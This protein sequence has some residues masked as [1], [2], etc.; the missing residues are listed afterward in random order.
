MPALLQ[1][2]VRRFRVQLVR[3]SHARTR[4]VL[5]AHQALLAGRLT[6]QKLIAELGLVPQLGVTGRHRV[7]EG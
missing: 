2:G 6:P 5:A 3:E 7:R 1:R 4:E